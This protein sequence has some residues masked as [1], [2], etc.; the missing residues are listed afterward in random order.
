[1]PIANSYSALRDRVPLGNER[2]PT[3]LGLQ[4]GHQRHPFLRHLLPAALNHDLAIHSKQFFW[5][6]QKDPAFFS[7]LLSTTADRGRFRP[8][9]YG[10]RGILRAI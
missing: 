5:L 10:V 4:F 1:M 8:D 9:P 3:A 7:K 2:N 6:V